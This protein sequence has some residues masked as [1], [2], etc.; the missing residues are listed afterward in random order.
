M[1]SYKKNKILTRPVNVTRADTLRI[2]IVVSEYNPDITEALYK[3]CRSTLLQ[4]GIQQD[5]IYRLDVPGAFE[6]PLGAKLIHDQLK[7]HAVICLGCVITGETRHSEYI[8]HAVAGELMRL[9]LDNNKP[10]VF[11]LLTPENDRQ[12]QDRAGGKYGNKGVEAATAALKMISAQQEIKS[13]GK[14]K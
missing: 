2:A 4:H 12:A 13:F 1:P 7:P 11:G 8:N 6:L 10:F 3:G 9:S 14:N 5:N